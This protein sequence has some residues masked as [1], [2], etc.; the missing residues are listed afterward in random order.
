VS[1]DRA[2]EHGTLTMWGTIG[3]SVRRRGKFFCAMAIFAGLAQTSAANAERSKEQS[4]LRKTL[5]NYAGCIVK[6]HHDKSA[7][8][9]L[10]AANDSDIRTKLSAIVDD[11]CLIDVQSDPTFLYFRSD[12]YLYA[13][14]DAL[15]QADY[16]SDGDKDFGNRLPLAQPPIIDPERQK[17]ELDKVKSKSRREELLKSFQKANARGWLM[18]YGECVVRKDPVNARFWLLTP[19]DTPEEVS[20]IKALQA[21]FSICLQEG[22]IKF[23][24]IT[25]RGAVAINYYRLAKAT[26]IPKAGGEP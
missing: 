16:L 4:E 25:M 21:V 19:P 6:R 14:A 24:R 3:F 17:A 13:I 18:R 12:S 2:A 26:V 8:A 22:T 10:S 20:R 7:A 1:D 5:Q 15:V 23:N 9:V 11:N